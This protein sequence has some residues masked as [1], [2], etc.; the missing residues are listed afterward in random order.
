[1][2]WQALEG[3][4]DGFREEKVEPELAESLR[5]SVRD[6]MRWVVDTFGGSGSGPAATERGEYRGRPVTIHRIDPPEHEA[7]D[8]GTTCCYFKWFTDDSGAT[9]AYERGYVVDAS[10]SDVVMIGEELIE[11]D[12][13]APGTSKLRELDPRAPTPT[14]TASPG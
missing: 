13:Y 3:N 10:G 11:T 7:P 14:P 9:I 8:E 6:R 2:T 5:A 1:M 4:P 12:T